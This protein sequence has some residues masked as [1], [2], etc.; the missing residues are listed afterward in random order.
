V[1]GRTAI[2]V[3]AAVVREYCRSRAYP[4]PAMEVRFCPGR[5]WRFDCSWDIR[6]RGRTV[7]VALEFQGGGWIR[8]RH[9]RGAGFEADCSKFSNAAILGWRVLLATVRQVE[10][11]T[12]FGWIDRLFAPRGD[13]DR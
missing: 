12:V 9:V 1:R 10:D 5:K 4:V 3:K 2:D 13:D 8:G 7:K 11:G 6:W